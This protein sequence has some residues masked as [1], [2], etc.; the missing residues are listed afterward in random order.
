MKARAE[1]KVETERK[2]RMRESNVCLESLEISEPEFQRQE[3]IEYV[4]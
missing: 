3:V 4:F 1:I 2:L